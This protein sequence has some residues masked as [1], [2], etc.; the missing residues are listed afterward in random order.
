MRPSVRWRLTLWHAGVL[1]LV[2]CAFAAG[3]FAFVRTRLYVA[4]DRQ[5]EA[6]LATIE[7]VYREETG[8]LGE[9][10]HRMGIAHFAV[11]EGSTIV[12]RTPGWPPSGPTPYRE[13]VLHDSS[14]HIVAARDEA[15]VRQTLWTL[16]IILGA[17]IPCAMALAIGGGYF[18]AG[19][20]LA[21]V[22]TM[23][24]TARDARDEDDAKRPQ[25]LPH[26]RLVSRGHREHARG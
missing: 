15:T 12:Y 20:M 17:G 24:E 11:M 9:L 25:C 4:L 22:A 21:P 1:T 13:R 2:I 8:D 26:R 10:A 3:I 19:R 7:T 14:H 6:D 23:A 18:L 16:G 5:V